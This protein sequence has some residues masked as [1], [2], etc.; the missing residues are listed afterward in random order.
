MELYSR[1]CEL[2]WYGRPTHAQCMQI[3]RLNIHIKLDL[4]LVD[5][6]TVHVFEFLRSRKYFH[7]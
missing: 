6:L 5:T 1:Q 2:L 4:V 3:F 7:H